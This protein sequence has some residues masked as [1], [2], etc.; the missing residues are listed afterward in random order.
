MHAP[1]AVF[2]WS[3]WRVNPTPCMAQ[4]KPLIALCL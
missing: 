4:H 2:G 1:R 3:S